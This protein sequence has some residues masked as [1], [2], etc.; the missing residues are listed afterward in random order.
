MSSDS[1]SSSSSDGEPFIYESDDDG[2]ATYTEDY[3][4]DSLI[5]MR[6]NDPG[7]TG[8]YA[9]GS[10]Q[11]IQEMT[12]E[13]WVQLGHDISHNDYL[14]DLNLYETLD[15][16]KT[17]LFFQGLTRSNTLKRINIVNNGIGVSGIQSMIPLFLSNSNLVSLCL[18]GLD[19]IKTEGF[20]LLFQ[21]LHNSPIERLD[22]NDCVWIQ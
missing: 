9:S 7:V 4:F 1:S 21:A 6:E 2:W 16:R 15:D 13:D 12:D 22:C 3:C 17:A 20:S 18:E 14:A 10:F 11:H 5:L 19:E 8:L